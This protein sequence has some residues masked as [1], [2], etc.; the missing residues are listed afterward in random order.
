MSPAGLPEGYSLDAA[1]QVQAPRGKYDTLPRGQAYKPW[2]YTTIA[3]I[4]LLMG[5]G[6]WPLP[7]VVPDIVLREYNDTLTAVPHNL[8][9]EQAYVCTSAPALTCP[10]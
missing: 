7:A 4:T 6:L 2:D 8:T 10:A 3:S 5:A 1:G 9:F